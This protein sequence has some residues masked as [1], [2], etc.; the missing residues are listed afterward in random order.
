MLQI[1]HSVKQLNFRQL[2]D[3]YSDELL[4]A[5][6]EQYDQF[7]LNLQILEAE[8]DF[9]HYLNEFFKVID[10]FYGIWSVEGTYKAALRIEPYQDG[11]LLSGLQT[12]SNSRK[13][14]YA[15]RLVEET[16]TYLSDKGVHMVYSHIH[17]KN[18][19][20]I[21]THRKCGFEKIFDYAVFLDGSVD[22]QSG[23]YQKIIK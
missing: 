9:Y 19:A 6:R 10:A 5:G 7:S 22:H 17:N 23:T 11:V 12:A 13:K 1:F 3:V 15:A 16:L 21:K 4:K 8:Q 18:V 14:G 20:S 2:C